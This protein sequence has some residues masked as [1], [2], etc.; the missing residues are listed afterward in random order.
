M[1]SE[2]AVARELKVSGRQVARFD[3]RRYNDVDQ[4]TVFR[5]PEV[6]SVLTVSRLERYEDEGSL[7]SAE[8]WVT[9][10]EL[11]DIAALQEFLEG[12]DCWRELLDAGHE[13]DAELYAAWVPH[14]VDRELD[15]ASIYNKDLAQA[16]GYLGG[17][18]V[19]APGRELPG[20]EAEAC[21]AMAAHLDELGWLVRGPISAAAALGTEPGDNVVV[22]VLEAWRYG[23]A[24]AVVVR[25]DFC[26][27][28]YARRADDDDVEGVPAL[29]ALT[30]G[31]E[32]QASTEQTRR[33][34]TGQ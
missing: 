19:P 20:W 25:V 9:V 18:P 23:W 22:G 4:V 27:E 31:E 5:G 8:A 15:R 2:A 14:Q 28:I 24:V 7:R 32:D 29:R 21:A 26:G 34:A 1:R 6:W 30:D 17:Q 12:R 11:A 10:T 16:T 33:Y 13:E 3:V